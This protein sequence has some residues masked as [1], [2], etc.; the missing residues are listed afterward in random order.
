[1]R[2]CHRLDHVTAVFL[3]ILVTACDRD[4]PPADFAE[5]VRLSYTGPDV[6]PFAAWDALGTPVPHLAVAVRSVPPVEPLLRFEFW[7]QDVD[8]EPFMYGRSEPFRN[9]TDADVVVYRDINGDGVPD[10]MGTVFDS[11]GLSQP[12]L[13][14]AG[15]GEVSELRHPLT[16]GAWGSGSYSRGSQTPQTSRIAA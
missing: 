9:V 10:L 11:L 15:L 3:A 12:V 7:A 1:M 6:D 13:I 16:P 8:G 4:P 2:R 14:F 5:R